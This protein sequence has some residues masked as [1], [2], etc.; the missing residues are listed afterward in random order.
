M[1]SVTS[2]FVMHYHTIAEYENEDIPT[3]HLT[4]EEPPWDPS[5]SEYSERDTWMLDHW[6]QL[7]FP[8]TVVMWPILQ[9]VMNKPNE[10]SINIFP[11]MPWDVHLFSVIP[12]FFGIPILWRIT[13]SVIQRQRHTFN[14]IFK[15]SWLP[16]LLLFYISFL[17]LIHLLQKEFLSFEVF[18]VWFH[19]HDL[20][21]FNKITSYAT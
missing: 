1:S 19:F 11:N 14:L 20:H 12:F 9:Y 15:S 17:V 10:I 21:S 7:N 13:M 16:F 4:A 3:I 18:S 2:Y 5:T 8:A 6:G